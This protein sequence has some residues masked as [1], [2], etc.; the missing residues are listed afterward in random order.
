MLT[1]Y[2]FHDGFSVRGHPSNLAS[3]DVFEHMASL[4]P[5]GDPS[6]PAFG[7]FLKA[8]QKS[9]SQFSSQSVLN[10]FD[11]TPGMRAHRVRGFMG[12]LA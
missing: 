7:V 11:R 2:F 12:L 3:R 8:S 4:W 5:L 9:V 1:V 10:S 6:A